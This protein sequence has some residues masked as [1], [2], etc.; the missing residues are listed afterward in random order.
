MNP[1]SGKEK[2]ADPE[3]TVR[4]LELQ[5]M[6]QRA[7]RQQAGTPYRGLRAMSFIFLFVIILGALLAFYYFFYLGGLDQARA[8]NNPPSPSATAASRSP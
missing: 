3:D 5:L 1:K 2:P 8:R 6:Q 7:A 4:M